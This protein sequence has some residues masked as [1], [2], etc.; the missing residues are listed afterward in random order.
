MPPGEIKARR[1]FCLCGF[2]LDQ[3]STWISAHTQY[4]QLG[5]VRYVWDTRGKLSTIDYTD[6]Y[7]DS[8]GRNT[9][10]HAT[11]STT[12]VP[13]STG[14]HGSTSA[15]TSSSIYDFNTGLVTSATDANG[16]TASYE[17]N[18]VMN[19]PTKVTRPDGGWS[20][21]SYGDTPGNLYVDSQTLIRSVPSQQVSQSRQF[22][23]KMGRS[24]RSFGYEGTTYLTSDT[25]YD[26][27][28]RVLKVSIPYRTYSFTD[29]ANPS[30]LWASSTYD[31]LGRVVTITASDSSQTSTAYSGSLTG[32]Y[33]GIP[34]DAPGNLR[35]PELT[36]CARRSTIST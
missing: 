18:D 12:A 2:R 3:T 14:V 11:L 5:N 7:S 30:G 8:V 21:T 31:A 28:G 9:C 23:D 6:A 4:N 25:V 17:Y 29:A 34:L 16:R 35:L 36:E 20:I 32:S 33:I 19:R 10:A 26:N 1:H 15:F 22:F 13:D 27:M 24:V